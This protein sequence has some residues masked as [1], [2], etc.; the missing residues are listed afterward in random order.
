VVLDGNIR[1]T[2]LTFDNL[3]IVIHSILEQDKKS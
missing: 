1:I 3:K 2:N